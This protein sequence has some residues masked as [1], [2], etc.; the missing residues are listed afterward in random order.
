MPPGRVPPYA[1]APRVGVL[2]VSTCQKKHTGACAR[3]GGGGQSPMEKHHVFLTPD[4]ATGSF[5]YLAPLGRS[6]PGLYEAL[7][8]HSSGFI[9]RP[10]EAR[11]FNKGGGV[12]R[13]LLCLFEE[14]VKTKP[15]RVSLGIHSTCAAALHQTGH[16]ITTQ[17]KQY[18]HFLSLLPERIYFVSSHFF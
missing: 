12:V 2:R 17:G 3:E 4:F 10:L 15:V 7:V 9:L 16:P 6:N 11:N 13:S 1:Q 8:D 5:Q 18:P 14:S